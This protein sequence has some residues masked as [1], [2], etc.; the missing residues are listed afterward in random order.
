[1]NCDALVRKGR[2]PWLPHGSAE[3][4]TILH[5]ND[6]PLI[7]VFTV[8][9][10]HRVLFA[11]L[12]GATSKTNV[13]AYAEIAD[14]DEADLL[15]TDFASTADLEEAVHEVFVGRRAVLAIAHDGEIKEWTADDVDDEGVTAASIRYM[16]MSIARMR[17]SRRRKAA[18][19]RRAEQGRADV[20][21]EALELVCRALTS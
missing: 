17:A 11:C 16:D 15:G 10:Q 20:T 14:S 12:T 4:L 7:G 6:F 3:D 13:W 9:G 1:M 19:H 18:A 8:D 2:E 5:L 21:R